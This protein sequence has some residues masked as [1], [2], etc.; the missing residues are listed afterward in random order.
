MLE[1]YSYA[2]EAHK[3]QMRRTGDPYITHPL[4]VADILADMRM[5]YQTLM[6]A[7]L[8]DV[9]EDTG[10]AKYRLSE[11]FEP[12]V[13]NM[14]DGVSKLTTIF[15]SQDE[16]RAQNFQKMALAVAKDIRIL[17]IKFADRLHN[18]QT[19]HAM[20]REKQ[21]RIA[22]ETLDFYAPI[23][24]RLGMDD[25]RLKFED[26]GFSYLYP[27]RY[28]CLEQAMKAG[29]GTH[30]RTLEK[31]RQNIQTAL[32]KDG[33]KA[34]V[35]GRQKHL[36]S[37]YSKM[38]Q[39][40]LSFKDL[41]DVLA[42]RVVVD[43]VDTCY[44]TVGSVHNLYRPIAGTFSD[45]I[46]IPKNNGY[47]SIHTCLIVPGGGRPIEVQIRTHDMDDVAT[48]GIAGH[49]LYKSQDQSSIAAQLK[50]RSWIRGLLDMKRRTSDS[51]EFINH[52]RTDLFQN[53]IYVFSPKGDIL[54]L[55]AGASP[56]DFAYTIS[57]HLGSSCSGCLIDGTP[58]PLSTPLVSG[59]TVDILT[60]ENATPRTEWLSFAVTARARAAIS[61]ALKRLKRVDAIAFGRELLQSSLT[62][63]DLKLDEVPADALQKL[64]EKLA[65]AQPDD[66]LHSIGIGNHV[67]YLTAHELAGYVNGDKQADPETISLESVGPATIRGTEGV[68]VTYA[69]CCNPI[70]GDAV[71]GH[72]QKNLGVSIHVETCKSITKLRRSGSQIY[73]VQWAEK[74]TGE[75][76]AVLC[77][78]STHQKATV[79]EIT[80]AASIHATVSG[81]RI[82]EQD[83]RL[84]SIEL[85][86]GVQDRDS[87]AKTIRTLRAIKDV[88]HIHRSR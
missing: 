33:I 38:K 25:L 67:A 15:T 62:S 7:L 22:R 36:Y 4:A 55:P 69:K 16:A 61:H 88:V 72:F 78:H 20:P 47:Q 8:H 52:L 50:V 86:L 3:G 32:E 63:M 17:L 74:T 46:A 66:L 12:T 11:Y 82:Q 1:A 5:D 13:A 84:A 51:K 40:H 59:Q 21:K 65:F 48:N 85:I 70:P 64:L 26:L 87:L 19:L 23:A 9:I 54:E 39:Q 6:A 60:S 53:E 34:T 28:T 81:I 43:D 27:M 41:T 31:I 77:I 42:F 24:L 14:V 57:T 49:W 18:M 68:V 75:F 71:I 44:R 29:H 10:I 56:I 80:T 37:I 58:V 83:A 76:R 30:K 73:S 2:E 79:A 35:T 45:Y